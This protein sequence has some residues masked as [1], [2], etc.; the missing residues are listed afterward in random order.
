MADHDDIFLFEGFRLDR[1]AGG[2][3]QLAEDGVFTPVPIGPRA[4]DVLCILVE[5]G[6]DLVTRDEI[7]AS[8]WPDTVVQDNNLNMQVAALRQ[9]LD[10]GTA[11]PS[12]IQTIPRR[13]YRFVA[14]VTRVRPSIEPA[15]VQPSNPSRSS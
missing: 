7:I 13:G 5:R 14:P 9:V 12:Y 8:V 6:G 10:G 1:R 2:L 3:S 11:A 15:P 4:L